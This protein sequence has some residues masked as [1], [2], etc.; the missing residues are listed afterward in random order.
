MAQVHL[1]G[2][3]PTATT[4]LNSASNYPWMRNACRVQSMYATSQ[5]PQ[6]PL[7]VQQVAFRYDGPAPAAI[8][9]FQVT[10]LT[11]LLGTTA[12][13][14][15]ALGADFAANLSQPLT[16]VVQAA[17]YS[18]VADAVT[19]GGPE[20]FGGPASQFLFPLAQSV[21]LAPGVTE[22]VVLE[23]QVQGNTN[24]FAANALL[25][26]HVEPGT[27]LPG[28][29]WSVGTGCPPPGGAGA[30]TLML[31]GAPFVPGSAISLHGSG[32]VP[33]APVVTLVASTLLPAPTLLPGTTCTVHLDPGTMAV[34]LNQTADSTGVLSPYASTSMLPIPV[35]HGLTG[36]T[37]HL[38]TVCVATSPWPGNALGL[39]T[40]NLRSLT[41]GTRTGNDVGIWFAA[42]HLDASA[43][44][45]SFVAV[46][47]YAVRLN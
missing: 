20:P 31:S 15:A 16:T 7:T 35:L 6:L 24:N 25:D 46:G 41:I 42:H 10:S 9:T 18:F 21:L 3:L 22:S 43:P 5:V 26:L 11:L 36:G 34:A 45:A 44:I 29:Q 37:L 14:T 39:Q 1:P 23:W 27:L 47:A 12:R 8:G 4:E 32:Y 38:Q 17:N 19:I 2:S 13:P 30:A 33:G 40:S 28:G